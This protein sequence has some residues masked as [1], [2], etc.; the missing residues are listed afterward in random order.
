MCVGELKPSP[1]QEH[2]SPDGNATESPLLAVPLEIAYSILEKMAESLNPERK[3]LTLDDHEEAKAIRRELI[4]NARSFLT[5]YSQ[6][7]TLESA[8]R[9]EFVSQLMRT[10]VAYS[11]IH[12]CNSGVMSLSAAGI[13]N[14]DHLL[15]VIQAASLRLK[16]LHI[17]RFGI[18]LTQERIVKLIAMCP[19]LEVI[20]LPYSRFDDEAVIKLVQGRPLR[21]LTLSAHRISSLAIKEIAK[22]PLKELHLFL[23]K[24]LTDD[25]VALI[26][27]MKT[28]NKLTITFAKKLTHNSRIKIQ[29][30]N[31]EMVNMQGCYE[32]G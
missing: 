29:E 3:P 27:S 10:G 14:Y 15:E 8:K 25:D 28:L 4:Q 31:F 2:K 13:K 12:A 5:V 6:A 11:L 24:E 9:V 32:E 23:A 18:T 20:D 26:C 19:R 17:D 22:L 7:Y 21:H 1:Y 16:Q 30:R